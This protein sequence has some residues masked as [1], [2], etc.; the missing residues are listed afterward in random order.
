MVQSRRNSNERRSL[1]PASSSRRSKTKE[2]LD[3]SRR[4]RFLPQCSSGVDTLNSLGAMQYLSR[5]RGS[6]DVEHRSQIDAIVEKLLHLPP[7]RSLAEIS[8]P[9]S[10]LTIEANDATSLPEAIVPTLDQAIV[11]PSCRSP[12]DSYF[13][14]VQLSSND[15]QILD[16][17]T[18]YE[19]HQRSRV[20]VLIQET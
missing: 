8:I 20:R 16:S 12:P 17:A 2:K 7:N 1:R 9:S 14:L 15:E 3:F 6:L 18:A 19:Y 13:P 4:L 5:L 11:E 10:T